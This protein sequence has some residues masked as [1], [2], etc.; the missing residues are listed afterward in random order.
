MYISRYLS[1]LILAVIS[2]SAFTGDNGLSAFNASYKLFTRGIEAGIT[3]LSFI[4]SANQDEY[5]YQYEVKT[6][7]IAALFKKVHIIEKSTW[8][9]DGLQLLP[10]AYSF[11]QRGSKIED[12]A[13]KFDWKNMQVIK[14]NN[15]KSRHETL[16]DNMQLLDKLLYQYALMYDMKNGIIPEKYNVLDY[17]KIRTYYFRTLGNENIETPIGTFDTVKLIKTRDSNN[18]QT[19][20]WCVKA[21]DYLPVKLEEYDNDNRVSTAIIESVSGFE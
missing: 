3:N 21:L 8:K 4:K 9:L 19:I 13:M 1:A 11:Q 18:K 20:M 6:T 5:I 16:P 7:G 2:T 10:L 17:R 15:G 14:I 12:N